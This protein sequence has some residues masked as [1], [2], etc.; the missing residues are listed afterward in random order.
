[1]CCFPNRLTLDW[2]VCLIFL[3]LKGIW[4]EWW[5]RELWRNMRG[6]PRKRI[7]KPGK[8]IALQYRF[9]NR[10]CELILA[11]YKVLIPRFNRRGGGEYWIFSADTVIPCRYVM[12][13]MAKQL[14]PKNKREI[15]NMH[16][17]KLSKMTCHVQIRMYFEEEGVVLPTGYD[18]MA[19]LCY[20]F[21]T[22]VV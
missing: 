14:K 12:L 16:I 9:L 20:F 17:T 3:Y 15:L 8:N 6:K 4:Q 5:K 18:P 22:V 1:M 13:L 7:G 21:C 11:S 19:T 2:L 10:S